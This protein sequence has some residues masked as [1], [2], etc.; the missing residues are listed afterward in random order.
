LPP[1]HTPSLHASVRVQSEPSSQGD[2][3]ARFGLLHVPLVGS[4]VPAS[5]HWS[6]GVH[7]RGVPMQIPAEQVSPDVQALP[8]SHRAVLLT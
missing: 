3:V 5:W 7:T 4:H 8:S 2:P 6:L 1:L